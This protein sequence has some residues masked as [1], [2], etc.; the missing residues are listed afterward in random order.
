MEPT[1][2]LYA[3]IGAAG[4]LGADAYLNSSTIHL[5]TSV[6]PIYEQRG[7]SSGVVE[8]AAGVPFTP[9]PSLD[10]ASTHR[11]SGIVSWQNLHLRSSSRPALYSCH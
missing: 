6:A 1:T 10:C 3:L 11:Q 9:L 4:L 8:A 5:Q 2:L 7:F